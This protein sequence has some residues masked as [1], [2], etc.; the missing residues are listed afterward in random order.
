MAISVYLVIII[1]YAFV[2]GVFAQLTPTFYHETC[3]NATSIVLG[4]VEEALQTDPRIAASLVRLHFHDCFVDGCD[5]SILLDNTDTITALEN[6][7]LGI[8]SCVDILVITLEE[9]VNLSG[10][11]SWDVPLGRKD[12][13]T[14]NITLANEAIP[15]PFV[16]RDQLKANFFNQG[17]NSTNLIVLS[18]K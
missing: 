11:P 16:T 8:V 9:S 18:G 14:T 7:C 15:S 4:I 3:P 1:F 6:A 13:L 17:L 10:G 12:S 2:V 5:G